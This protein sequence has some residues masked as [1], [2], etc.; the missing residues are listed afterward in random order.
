MAR[1]CRSGSCECGIHHTARLSVKD[2]LCIVTIDLTALTA[3]WAGCAAL[4]LPSDWLL[5]VP[6]I[7]ISMASISGKCG[8]FFRERGRA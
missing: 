7:L 6:L 4:G 3:R 8:Q 5:E 2:V 1:A